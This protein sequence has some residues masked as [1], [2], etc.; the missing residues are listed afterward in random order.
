MEKKMVSEIMAIKHKKVNRVMIPK[1]EVVMLGHH[2]ELGQAIEIYR[3]N[4]FSRYPI[5]YRNSDHVVGILHIKDIVTFWHDHRDLPV[6]EFA[7]LPHFFYEDRSVLE[8]FLEL[9]RLRLS[10]AIVI[11]EFGG[12]SGIVAIEDLLEEIVGDIEDEFD[13]RKKPLIERISEDEFIVSARMELDDFA[14]NFGIRVDEDDVSTLAGLIS[15]H[16]DRIPKL[17]EEIIY[18]NL[19]FTILEGT[20]KK[21]LKV[22]LKRTR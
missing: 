10:M 2:V 7:R 1:N 13:R 16:A 11:D 12:V 22:R 6:I 15:K 4:H 19:K 3:H 20:R 21:I 8:V 18:K 9:Q 17:G 5:Y 14:E